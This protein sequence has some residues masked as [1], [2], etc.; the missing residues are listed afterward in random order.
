MVS[1]KPTK[2]NE[3][4]GDTSL[5]ETVHIINAGSLV[6]ISNIRANTR[7]DLPENKYRGHSKHWSIGNGKPGEP[8]PNILKWLHYA[9]DKESIY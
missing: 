3:L 2:T 5:N 9:I 6:Y 7:Y 4:F 8:Y 1:I